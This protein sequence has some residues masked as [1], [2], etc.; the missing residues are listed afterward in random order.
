VGRSL[1][2]SLAAL[3]VLS[4]WRRPAPSDLV[5]LPSRGD[6]PRCASPRALA[7]PRVISFLSSS[8]HPARRHPSRS[9]A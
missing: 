1:N 2:L 4:L 6:L 7:A 5:H 8:A 3:S 9:E